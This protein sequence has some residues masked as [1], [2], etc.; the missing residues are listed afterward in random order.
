[1]TRS[2]DIVLQGSANIVV[3]GCAAVDIT[4]QE[5]PNTDPG[6]AKHSTASGHVRFSL[7]GVARNVAEAT[8]RILEA[9]SSNFSSILLAPVG[10][11]PFGQTLLRESSSLGMRTDGLL[12]FEDETSAVCNIVLES[13]GTLVGGV[14]DMGI[15]QRM[16][17]D[18]V[19]FIIS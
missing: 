2:L 13:D 1:M 12:E 8:H 18:A 15:N 10:K 3:V 16:T 14:A 4:A 19:G 9:K 11:D 7:G 5:L 6:L 17:A